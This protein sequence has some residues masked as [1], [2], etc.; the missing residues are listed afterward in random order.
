VSAERYSKGPVAYGSD[1]LALEQAV[2]PSMDDAHIAEI[3]LQKRAREGASIQLAHDRNPAPER[4]CEFFVVIKGAI[5][6]RT[7]VGGCPI[8]DVVGRE[9]QLS[10]L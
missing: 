8:F 9:S 5:A 1:A 3:D 7:F 4:R 6:N 10:C 2:D